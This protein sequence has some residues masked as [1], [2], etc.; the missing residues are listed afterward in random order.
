MEHTTSKIKVYQTNNYKLFKKLEGNRILNNKKIERIIKEIQA[1][2]DVLDEVP[3]L[4][5]QSGHILVVLDGQHRLE[6]AQ[7]LNRPVHYIVHQHNMNIHNV[8]KVNSNTEK[9][10]SSDFVNCYATAGNDN[11]K[12]IEKFRTTYNVAIGSCLILLTYGTYKS[13]SGFD[14]D[15]LTA[16]FQTGAFEVKK[17]KEATIIMEI[18]KSFSAFAGWNTRPFIVAICRILDAKKAELDVLVKK[19]TQDTSKLRTHPSWKE[20]LVNLEE[21]YNIGNSKRRVIY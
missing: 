8:A 15:N 2:N 12:K 20:Y 9:W 19:F 16:A 11:Y 5:K 6:V 3:V 13:D 10:K 7:K 18:C 17:H 14:R 21:I 1:G 4:V